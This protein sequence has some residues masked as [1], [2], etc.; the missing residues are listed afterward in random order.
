MINRLKIGTYGE[1]DIEKEGN[2]KKIS[3]IKQER[4]K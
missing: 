2:I 4:M 1:R 3:E